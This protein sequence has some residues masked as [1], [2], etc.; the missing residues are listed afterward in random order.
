MKLPDSLRNMTK[1]E[2][3]CIALFFAAFY[4]AVVIDEIRT[5]NQRAVI[6]ATRHTK[7]I[8]QLQEVSNMIIQDVTALKRWANGGGK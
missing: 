8:Q 3:L 1:L 6:I 5:A 2:A 7:E 4:E